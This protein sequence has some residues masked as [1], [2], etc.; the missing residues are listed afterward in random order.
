MIMFTAQNLIIRCIP[1]LRALIPPAAFDL[2]S[3][4]DYE[5][6]LELIFCLCFDLLIAV[7]ADSQANRSRLV[8]EGGSSI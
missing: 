6:N 4:A 5:K 1:Y 2:S 3:K 8:C 7:C